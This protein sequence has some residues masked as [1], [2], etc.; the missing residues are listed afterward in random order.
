MAEYRNG[1]YGDEAV[2]AM[3]AHQC[4]R[5]RGLD[6]SRARQVEAALAAAAGLQ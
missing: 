1:V 6:K 3:A 4:R 2:R 5:H